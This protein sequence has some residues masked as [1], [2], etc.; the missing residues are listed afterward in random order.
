MV[1]LPLFTYKMS[2]SPEGNFV[3]R[4]FGAAALLL[5]LVLVLFVFSRWM[6]GRGRSG[7]R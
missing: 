6:A 3:S 5:L 7:T 1:S 4:A 2:Q